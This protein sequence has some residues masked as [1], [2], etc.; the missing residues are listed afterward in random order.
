MS[1]PLSACKLWD[2]TLNYAHAERTSK[3]EVFLSFRLQLGPCSRK[4]LEISHWHKSPGKQIFA[5]SPSKSGRSSPEGI[6]LSL[7]WNWPCNPSL[8]DPGSTTASQ[9]DGGQW[10]GL[11]KR[12][13]CLRESEFWSLICLARHGGD[14]SSPS[15]AQAM[16]LSKLH[17]TLSL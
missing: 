10:P 11:V 7:C 3:D 2:K 13:V 14:C 1:F 16:A 17:F 15:S 9:Q 5:A 4:E 8:S 6:R 12:V